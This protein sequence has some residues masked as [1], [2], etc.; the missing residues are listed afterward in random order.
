MSR[1]RI[2]P[3]AA[4]RRLS[5]RRQLGIL[6]VAV[7]IVAGAI[8][9][10]LF[11]WTAG[12][13]A[14]RNVG[15]VADA[16][17]ENVAV[18]ATRE[19][20]EADFASLDV[21]A[22][23]YA[24]LPDVLRL[25]V[26]DDQ[27]RPVTQARRAG[28]EVGPVYDVSATMPDVLPD[29]PSRISLDGAR[30]IAVW[31]PIEIGDE[32]LGFVNVDVS[33]TPV[34]VAQRR[35][36]VQGLLSGMAVLVMTLTV[37]TL[38]LRRPI[39]SLNEATYF[40]SNLD[41]KQG[42]TLPVASCNA[43]F[44]RLSRALN[45]VSLR[46]HAHSEALR[47]SEAWASKL[48][49]VASRTS[50]AVVIT[51]ANVRI[52]WVNEGFE[53]I[54]GYSLDEVRGEH[55]GRLLQGP[56]TDQAVVR[57]IGEKVRRGEGFQVELVNYAKDGR[58]YWVE[59]EAQ[60]LK[61][62]H[63]EVVQYMAIETDVTER[64]R[65]AAELAERN[66]FVTTIM[67]TVEQGITVVGPDWRFVYVNP[68]YERMAGRPAAELIGRSPVELFGD[69][70]ERDLERARGDR[71]EGRSSSYEMTLDRPD[72]TEVEV[73]VTGVPRVRDGAFDGTISVVSDVTERNRRL[74]ELRAARDDAEQANEAKSQFL[75]RMSHELRT[76]LNAILGYSQLLDLDQLTSDQHDSVER[77]KHA[78]KHLLA[79][80]NEVLDLSRIEAGH[81]DVMLEPVTV[82]SALDTA[83]RMVK[84]LASE[85]SIRMSRTVDRDDTAVSADAKRFQQVLLNLLSNAIKYNR[86]GGSITV[87]SRALDEATLRISVR[88]SGVGIADEK[89][90]RLFMPFDRLDVNELDAV[91]GTGIGLALTKRLVEV[92]GGRIG[93]ESSHGEGSTFWIELP[94]VTQA[95]GDGE[96]AGDGV[97]GGEDQVSPAGQSASRALLAVYV[98]D[99]L[100]NLELVRKIAART[101]HLELQGAMDG[102]LGLDL[103]RTQ[104]P[105]FVL[106]DLR[107]PGMSGEEVLDALEAD[108]ATRRIP[109]IVLSADVSKER[110][111]ALLERPSVVS[112]LAKPID[113]EQLLD[114]IAAV[115]EL[116]PDGATGHDRT[117]ARNGVEPESSL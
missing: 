22:A 114:T 11:A 69:G 13:A 89:L 5:F 10:G 34:A 88:D 15:A 30:A 18:G 27:R 100:A 12:T 47:A 29:G 49:T 70:N 41:R 55:P 33:F 24:S 44:A 6:V 17:A 68:A 59:V 14:L 74:R 21:L 8:S 79:L 50:N 46:L 71:A 23:E 77:I 61:D 48:A 76:P 105:D 56:D 116:V 66:A 37:L 39:R 36:L 78:G 62:E 104:Q 26:F 97:T 67:D 75:S 35:G 51:D 115:S 84:P 2:S 80:I 7:S 16:L 32:T 82:A 58:K 73:L 25:R 108:P 63:G 95:E 111:L 92:M 53:R 98:E 72:G 54:T 94:L 1:A 103:I 81:E 60:P 106:L 20:L 101:T 109:V 110:I 4:F 93:A 57:E 90:H 96:R 64:K 9:G 3:I 31:R 99:N 19:L 45:D 83:M 85:R 43:D 117:P 113:V 107:L 102:S 86:E 52:D 42:E 28:D 112:F 40:A 38:Y 87:T 65:A 91:E